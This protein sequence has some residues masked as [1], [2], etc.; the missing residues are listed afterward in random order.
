MIIECENDA[1]MA[2]TH[3]GH[4]VVFNE[5]N[6]ARVKKS[7]GEQLANELESIS[8]KNRETNQED[9]E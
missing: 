6:E 8:I 2:M 3:D 4:R 1:T 5:D 9:D 7:V